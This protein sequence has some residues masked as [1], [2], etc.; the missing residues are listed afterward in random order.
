[1]EFILASRGPMISFSFSP[2][3]PPGFGGL[4]AVHVD[5]G[6]SMARNLDQSP[7]EPAG[8]RTGKPINRRYG[9]AGKISAIRGNDRV[10]GEISFR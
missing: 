3:R 1:M 4:L 9:R 2:R 7:G 10:T 5:E 6:T 8:Q